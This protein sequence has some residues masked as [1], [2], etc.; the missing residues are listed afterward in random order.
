MNP[1]EAR[2]QKPLNAG[3]IFVLCL[4]ALG[5]HGA[6]WPQYRGPTGDGIAPAQDLPL[7][8]SAT[9]N[10]AWKTSLPGRG[11]SSPVIMGNRIWLTTALET[12]PRKTIAGTDPVTVVDRAEVGVVCLA[13]D[14]GKQLYHV[15]LFRPEQPPPAHELNSFATPTPVIEAGRLYCDFGAFGTA[16]LEA[17]TGRVLWT[18][19]ITIDHQLAPASSPVVWKNLLLLVRDG[20]DRQFVAAL[21]KQTGRI[22]W[23]TDRPPIEAR[24]DNAK[25]S[26]STP[27]VFEFGGRAQM[28]VP[29]A[30]WIVSYDPATGRELWR[31]KHGTSFSIGPRPVFGHGLV[32]VLTGMS[33]QLWA[34]RPDGSGDVTK[35]H[36]AW[37][38][39]AVAGTMAS[40]LLAGGE[41][42]V[43]TD[44]GLVVCLDALT[45]AQVGR[46][47][48]GGA[49]ASS[50]MLSA[51]R[52][53]LFGRKGK[54]TVFRAG[55]ELEVLAENELEGTLFTC[56]AAVE[57]ALYIRT[58][59]AIYC[60]RAKHPD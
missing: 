38:T 14:T 13:R 36:V 1:R 27:A 7:T 35:T 17:D 22:V 2:S 42:Y 29:C 59:D 41:I 31:V 10:L 18:N 26:F 16:C 44:Q 43:V 57:N 25:K 55:R 19:Q 60:V 52:I 9:S 20:R 15:T 48:T 46:R 30:H 12:N 32:Y 40:P 37:K 51:D 23:Q 11:R 50:P 6:D 24:S 53:Y 45:G 54:G 47:G 8:W 39:E 21:D 3:A 56:P 33:R 28:V 4:T 34:I 5:C 58:D 49:V